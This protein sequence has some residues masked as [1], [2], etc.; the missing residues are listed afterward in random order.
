MYILFLFF[1]SNTAMTFTRLHFH[2][3]YM[4]SFHIFLS[5][6]YLVLLLLKLITYVCSLHPFMS[7]LIT[8]ILMKLPLPS[9]TFHLSVNLCVKKTFIFFANITF[10]RSSFTLHNTITDFYIVKNIS[11]T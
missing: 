8:A 3:F 5:L 9:S 1:F 7:I 2:I 10:L 6:L 4:L 11:Y